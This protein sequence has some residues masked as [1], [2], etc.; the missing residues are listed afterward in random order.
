MQAWRENQMQVESRQG[1]LEDSFFHVG[2]REQMQTKSKGARHQW[3]EWERREMCEVECKGGK[4][5]KVKRE[6]RKK[7]RE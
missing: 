2:S 6:R 3:L 5:N 7:R 4:Q 1:E